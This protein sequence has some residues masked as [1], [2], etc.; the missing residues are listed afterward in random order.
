MVLETRY[1]LFVSEVLKLKPERTIFAIFCHNV[2]AIP[3]M[4]TGQ[5][6]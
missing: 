6:L 1:I 2:A 5:L 3:I 4:Q